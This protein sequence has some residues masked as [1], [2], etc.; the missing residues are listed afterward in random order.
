MDEMRFGTRTRPKR[1]GIGEEEVRKNDWLGTVSF[2]LGQPP[3]YFNLH[4][5]GRWGRIERKEE[6]NVKNGSTKKN[7]YIVLP[8]KVCWPTS[9]EVAKVFMA[10]GHSREPVEKNSKRKALQYYGKISL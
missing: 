9:C 10:N 7:L 8:Q 3:I 2:D 4:L 5:W 6:K 1:M